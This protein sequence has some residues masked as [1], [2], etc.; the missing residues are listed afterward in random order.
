[1][2]ELRVRASTREQRFRL[3]LRPSVGDLLVGQVLRLLTGWWREL[4]VTGLVVAVDV[5]AVARLGGPAGHLLPV[6]L[7]A[8][9]LGVPWSRRP[10]AGWLAGGRVRRRWAA[11]VPGLRPGH[12]R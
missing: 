1:M 6:G 2:P 5:Y 7:G 8:L 11:A 4:A 12:G 9:L 10:L 3:Q